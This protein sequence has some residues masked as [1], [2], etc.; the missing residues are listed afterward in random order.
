MTIPAQF[1]ALLLNA[2]ARDYRSNALS[3]RQQRYRRKHRVK[4]NA[5]AVQW[6]AENRERSRAL[7][8]ASKRR[9]KASTPSTSSLGPE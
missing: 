9:S 1:L 5:Y 2:F 3:I 6:R 8:R 4:V 7:V